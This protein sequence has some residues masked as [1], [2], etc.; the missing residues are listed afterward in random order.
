MIP[1]LPPG[2]VT[3][4]RHERVMTGTIFLPKLHGLPRSSRR[5]TSAPQWSS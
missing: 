4:H 2:L 1:D 3:S 5:I